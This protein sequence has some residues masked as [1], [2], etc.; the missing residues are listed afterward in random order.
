MERR[1][2]PARQRMAGSTWKASMESPPRTRFGAACTSARTPL[3]CCRRRSLTWD[4]STIAT[5]GAITTNIPATSFISFLLREKKKPGKRKS[6]VDVGKRR[7]S[8]GPALALGTVVT[9]DGVPDPV[10]TRQRE[11]SLHVDGGLAPDCPLL[12]RGPRGAN[13]ARSA[14]T[15]R[16]S[17]YFSIRTSGARSIFLGNEFVRIVGLAVAAG[18]LA[19][20]QLHLGARRGLVVDAPEQMPDD[21]QARPPLVIRSSHV[22]RGPCGI[23]GREHLVTRP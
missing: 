3:A 5:T 23:G 8:I 1:T 4:H 9:A 22:P 11:E 10:T 15:S 12:R 14:G 6:A 20:R 19:L 17:G 7:R 2:R 18:L 13:G 21:V 16:A